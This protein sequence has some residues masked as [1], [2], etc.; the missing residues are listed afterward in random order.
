LDRRFR[1]S[2]HTTRR[3]QSSA[4][5]CPLHLSQLH[6]LGTHYKVQTRRYLNTLVTWARISWL[7]LRQ[8]CCSWLWCGHRMISYD[9]IYLQ[10]QNRLKVGTDNPKL[11]VKMKS[12][13]DDD[14]RKRLLEKPRFEQAAKV[15]PPAQNVAAKGVFRLGRCYIFRQGVPG[16]WASNQKRTAT[17]G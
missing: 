16:L 9:I 5:D 15:S 11:K 14:I 6:H 1:F 8:C 3:D 13:S 10:R 7:A 4:L 2:D 12:V 17:D